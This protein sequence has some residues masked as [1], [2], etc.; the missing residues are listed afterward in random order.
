MFTVF[1]YVFMDYVDKQK[2]LVKLHGLLE[3]LLDMGFEFGND[4]KDQGNH[5]YHTIDEYIR[6]ELTNGIISVAL[7]KHNSHYTFYYIDK[8]NHDYL[9][10]DSY[11]E[12]L[13][14]KELIKK[15]NRFS[16][17]RSKS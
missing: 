4:P 16:K 1:D 13:H 6:A 12:P 5:T 15:V 11:E 10:W 9:L 17:E 7:I 3:A 2:K 14:T 8:N